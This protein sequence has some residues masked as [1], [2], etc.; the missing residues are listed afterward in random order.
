MESQH[1]KMITYPIEGE[2]IQLRT[3][4][5]WGTWLEKGKGSSYNLLHFFGF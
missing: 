5:L 4:L 2:C 1:A 3:W